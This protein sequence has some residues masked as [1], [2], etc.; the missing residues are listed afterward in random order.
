MEG[1]YRQKYK[2]IRAL[3][4]CRCDVFPLFL[5]RICCFYF[6]ICIL[7]LHHLRWVHC[8]AQFRCQ[9]RLCLRGM[10]YAVCGMRYEMRNSESVAWNVELFFWY[11]RRIILDTPKKLRHSFPFTSRSVKSTFGKLRIAY[12]HTNNI[13]KKQKIVPTIESYFCKGI[14]V[15]CTYFTDGRSNGPEI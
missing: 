15:T 1:D 9:S 4:S 8:S 5:R 12:T 7:R 10:R 6:C 2:P 3:R 14:H 11:S 13:I